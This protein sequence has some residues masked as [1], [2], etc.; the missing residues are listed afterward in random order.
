MALHNHPH[1]AEETKRRVKEEAARCGYRPEP[2]LSALAAY[3]QMRKPPAYHGNLAWIYDYETWK[4]LMSQKLFKLY[5]EGA[6]KRANELGYQLEEFSLRETPPARLSEILLARGV[7]GILVAPLLQPE[8]RIEMRWERFSSVAFGFSLVQPRLHMISSTQYRIAKGAALKMQGL[9]YQ[10][11][12]FFCSKTFDERTDQNFSAGF[13]SASL[14]VP[15]SRRIPPLQLSEKAS[16]SKTSQMLITRWRIDAV[17][18]GSGMHQPL[19]AAGYKI[20]D[21]IAVALLGCLDNSPR[22]AGMDENGFITGAAAV[23]FLVAMIHRGER[24]VPAVPYELLIEGSWV[25]GPSAPSVA[26][27]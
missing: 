10:R 7:Q 23:D 15:Q 22:F 5:Y 25:D 6:C 12:G 17:L 14:H 16:P 21:D 3:R 13:H 18:C 20:P 4:A 1:I 8:T 2:M 26:S 19:T 9:G 24:G 11:I 27:A